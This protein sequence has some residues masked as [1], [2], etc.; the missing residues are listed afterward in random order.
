VEVFR[1]TISLPYVFVGNSHMKYIW[2]LCKNRSGSLC[3]Y[4]CCCDW[5]ELWYFGKYSVC[6]ICV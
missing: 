3:N 1:K 2:K 5:G 4:C 6:F